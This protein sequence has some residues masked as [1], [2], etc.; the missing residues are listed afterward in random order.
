MYVCGY[1]FRMAKEV[2]RTLHAIAESQ[3]GLS[4]DNA[5]S[6]MMT[7]KGNRRYMRDVY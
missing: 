7:L 2:D 3:G 4:Q 1:A 6:Y 5:R